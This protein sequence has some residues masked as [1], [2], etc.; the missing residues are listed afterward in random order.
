MVGRPLA[1]TATTTAW[2]FRPNDV[3]DVMNLVPGKE[4]QHT[5]NHVFGLVALGL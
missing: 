5:H 3:D 2:Q 1:K 4:L